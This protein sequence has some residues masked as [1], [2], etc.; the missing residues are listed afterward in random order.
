MHAIFWTI[1]RNLKTT[2]VLSLSYLPGEIF[3]LI[4]LYHIGK[5]ITRGDRFK[6]NNMYNSFIHI[7]SKSKSAMP[8]TIHNHIMVKDQHRC[9]NERCG[10]LHLIHSK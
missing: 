2:F 5:L 4:N 9:S 8:N 6:A 7:F 10:P 3:T 1:P